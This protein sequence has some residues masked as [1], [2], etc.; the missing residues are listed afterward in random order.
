MVLSLAV[1]LLD[2]KTGEK[3]LI[4]YSAAAGRHTQSKKRLLFG[5][6]FGNGKLAILSSCDSPT[7][8]CLT[9]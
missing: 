5:L 9:S 3:Y 1:I 6:F 8:I 2:S 4:M 7:R